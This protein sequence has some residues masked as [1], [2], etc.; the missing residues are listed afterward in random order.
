MRFS[1]RYAAVWSLLV[2][3]LFSLLFAAKAQLNGVIA[4]TSVQPEHADYAVNATGRIST[5]GL[6]AAWRGEG[7][8]SDRTGQGCARNHLF[9]GLL[10]RLFV[11]DTPQSD[12]RSYK[13]RFTGSNQCFGSIV[14]YHCWLDSP[15]GMIP[16]AG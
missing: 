11:C 1:L 4:R 3:A 14:R 2:I 8:A 16:M 13:R 7:N 9:A 12:A 10:G 15:D 6:V 5:R